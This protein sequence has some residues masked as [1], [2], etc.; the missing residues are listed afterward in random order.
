[1]I[2]FFYIGPAPASENCAQTG[3]T[4]GAERLNRIECN[5]YITA[6]RTVYGPEPDKAYYRIKGETHDFGR[7]YEVC[8]YFDVNDP[9]A[10]AYASRAEFGLDYWA[11]AGMTAPV[12]YDD[13]SQP[14]G[15]AA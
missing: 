7:Y 14:I 12:Q 8:I 2:D 4:E 13:N 5:A 9:E 3:H 6:L 11:D 15:I 10:L 1:M